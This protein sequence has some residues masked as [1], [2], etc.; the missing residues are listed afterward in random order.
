MKVIVEPDLV[1]QLRHD[2][3][4][5][6]RDEV[7]DDQDQEEPDQVRDEPE[8]AVEALLKTVGDFH[9]CE[10]LLPPCWVAVVPGA[11]ARPGQREV[12]RVCP[13]V[14]AQGWIRRRSS[15]SASSAIAWASARTCCGRGRSATACSSPVALRAATACTASTTNGAYGSC[16]RS[17]GAGCRPPRRPVR[18]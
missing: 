15:A 12:S 8:H 17:C 5:D 18:S 14:V 10:H 16:R 7:A 2:G 11:R 1:E 6:P 3:L 9:C 4:D 13:G